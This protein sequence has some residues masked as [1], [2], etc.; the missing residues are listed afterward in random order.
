MPSWLP[1][2]VALVGGGAMGAL[3]KEMFDRRKSRTKTIP[4][5]ELVNRDPLLYELKGVRLLQD[6]AEPNQLYGS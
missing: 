1:L 3:I 6:R 2:L 4:L 5:I